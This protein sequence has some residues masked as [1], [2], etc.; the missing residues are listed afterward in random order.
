MRSVVIGV[1]QSWESH[2]SQLVTRK[3]KVLKV[4][5][6]NVEEVLWLICRSEDVL[7]TLKTAMIGWKWRYVYLKSP[8]DN[9][10]KI[11]RV[12]VE[13]LSLT[14]RNKRC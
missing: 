1:V 6:A 4:A 5:L 11:D 7:L 9:T 14:W 8:K 13:I 12:A 10:F 3:W 2:H